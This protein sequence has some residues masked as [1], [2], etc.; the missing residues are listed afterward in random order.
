MSFEQLKERIKKTFGEHPLKDDEISNVE[1]ALSV[2]L[3]QDFIEINKVCSYEY[4]NVLSFLNFGGTGVIENTLGVWSYFNCPHEFIMLYDDGSGVILM[5]VKNNTGVIYASI[6][7]TE[8]IVFRKELS[9]KHDLFPTFSDFFLY[10]LD[11]EEKRKSQE[12]T[13]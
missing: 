3:P 5:D 12:I 1:D 7:D 6:E 2:K 11:E 8:S 10:L 13:E 4:S 9:Y